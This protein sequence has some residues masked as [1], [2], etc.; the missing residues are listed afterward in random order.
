MTALYKSQYSKREGSVRLAL[1][2]CL[3]LRLDSI[4]DTAEF[5]QWMPLPED[6][7]GWRPASKVLHKAAASHLRLTFHFI[8]ACL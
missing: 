4:E 3:D 2:D 1:Q 6:Y 7:L 5:I 8:L